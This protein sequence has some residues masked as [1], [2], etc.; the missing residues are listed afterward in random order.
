MMSKKIIL[1][2]T[3]LL[4]ICCLP[5]SS[6]EKTTPKEEVVY[7]NLNNDGTVDQCYVVNIMYPQNGEIIDYGNYT[8]I[9]NLTTED[10]LTLKDNKITATTQS[11]KLYYQGY[12][13]NT[14]IPWNIDIQ[15]KLDNKIITPS[16]LAG[17]QGHLKINININKNDKCKEDFF[18]NY[19]MQ[20]SLSLDTKQCK[21]IECSGA[22][23][24][25]VGEDKQLTYTILPGKTKSIEI[26]T[27]VDNFELGEISFN[28]VRLDLGLDINNID[29]GEL[30]EQIE[31]IQNAISSLDEGA[32]GINDGALSLSQGSQS[33]QDGIKKI[34]EGLET[35]NQNSD[36]LTDGSNEVKEALTTINDALKNVDLNVEKLQLLVESS[37]QIKN[38]ID[39]V[40][41]GLNTINSGISQYEL[42]VGS[43]SQVQSQTSLMI[44]QLTLLKDN[45][46]DE[47]TKQLYMQIISLLQAGAASEEVLSSIQKTLIST[48]S[49]QTLMDGA[50]TLQSSYQQFDSSIAELVSQLSS[51]I[52]NMS[53]LKNGISLLLEN[54]NALDS[55]IN[56][57]TEAVNQI[58]KGYSKVYEGSLS[59]TQGTN[60]MYIA[61]KQLVEGSGEF[62][63]ETRDIDTMVN[64]SIEDVINEITANDYEVH[65][66]ISSYNTNVESVQFVIKTSSIKQEEIE[67][68][69]EETN[70]PSVW[71]KILEF[72][73]IKS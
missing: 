42:Q 45:S 25:N 28:G 26:E 23:T 49:N 53:Q 52:S 37:S 50:L 60:E 66:F 40:V 20:V 57:Y 21:N 8:S 51:L 13:D 11:S 44:Q 7:V 69:E 19:A 15:Y 38:G 67:M 9:K 70:Q 39:S 1:I 33:L 54:Y 12:L 22:T 36:Y 31:K 48:G 10:E 27:D 63:N 14:Q 2:M 16:D 71:D 6:L 34:Q 29:T 3:C 58:V 59:L 4:M 55:G 43:I 17:S 35:L 72:F 56:D 5:V 18:E 46:E 41:Y 24:A 61:T 62:K 32:N 73:G 64:D 30:D 47:Q 65:S 68:I